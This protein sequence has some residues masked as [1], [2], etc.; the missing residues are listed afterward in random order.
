MK[1]SP[2]APLLMLSFFA[3]APACGEPG[4]EGAWGECD[5]DNCLQIDDDGVLFRDDGTAVQLEIFDEAISLEKVPY[6]ERSE[7][8]E[9]VVAWSLEGDQLTITEDGRDP[10]STRIVIN[11]NRLT[12]FHEQRSI[13]FQRLEE[14][15]STGRCR[16]REVFA[17]PA[18]GNGG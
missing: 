11:Q 10:E 6:C 1:R 8:E 2:F 12:V 4:L 5:D 18:P 17:D 15:F 13:R 3:L 7:T 9:D 16:E 14:D